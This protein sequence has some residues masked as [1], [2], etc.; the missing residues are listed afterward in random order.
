MMKNILFSTLFMMIGYYSFGQSGMYMVSEQFSASN[1]T[2]LDKVV[3]T[4][5]TG[6]T[7][8]TNITHFMTNLE[9]HDSELNTIFNQITSQGY[10]LHIPLHQ[11]F[12]DF[13]FRL[14]HCRQL[15]YFYNPFAS[16]VVASIFC[17]HCR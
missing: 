16:Y 15:T 12:G 6:N 14:L 1:N 7:T 13:N 5:P 2:T 11:G 3:V 8:T 9:N 4:D 17:A 10:S